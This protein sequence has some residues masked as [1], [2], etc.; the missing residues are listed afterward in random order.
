MRLE[1]R[2]A[3]TLLSSFLSSGPSP[4]PLDAS[5]C[6]PASCP[7]TLHCRIARLKRHS[8]LGMSFPQRSKLANSQ[9]SFRT[10]YRSPPSGNL[11]CTSG[12]KAS[13]RILRAPVE[14]PHYC[15]PYTVYGYTFTFYPP[16]HTARNTE[17]ILFIF[18]LQ[19][20]TSAQLTGGR[21]KYVLAG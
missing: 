3:T 13:L 20:R 5:V 1:S 18:D 11:V 7:P 9:S 12:D 21:Q 2:H 19:S 8:H 14:R 10:Q 16:N 4:K 6:F 17:T 15:S